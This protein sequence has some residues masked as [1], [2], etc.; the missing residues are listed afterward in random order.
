MND[1]LYYFLRFI[2]RDEI[3]VVYAQ[4]QYYI[5]FQIKKR[6]RKAISTNR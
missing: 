2:L 5:Q 4:I 6:Y 3:S 1:S